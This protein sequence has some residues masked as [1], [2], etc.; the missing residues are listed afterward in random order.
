MVKFSA[1]SA[2]WAGSGPEFLRTEQ[3]VESWLTKPPSVAQS[4][5]HS[6]VLNRALPYGGVCVCVGVS[7]NNDKVRVL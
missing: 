4:I 1:D 2:H 3:S 7:V 6:S 5:T